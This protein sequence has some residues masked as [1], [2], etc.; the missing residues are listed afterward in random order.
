LTKGA[1]GRPA[2]SFRLTNR[3]VNRRPTVFAQKRQLYIRTVDGMSTALG[4]SVDD[5]ALT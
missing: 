3:I 1:F 5:A 4:P 2:W